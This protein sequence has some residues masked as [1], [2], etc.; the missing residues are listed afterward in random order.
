MTTHDGG[1]PEPAAAYA[2]LWAGATAAPRNEDSPMYDALTSHAVPMC[3]NPDAPGLGGSRG[4]IAQ[5]NGG[6]RLPTCLVAPGEMRPNRGV[7]IL[8]VVVGVRPCIE[9]PSPAPVSQQRRNQAIE[10]DLN[11]LGSSLRRVIVGLPPRPTLVLVLAPAPSA[12]MNAQGDEV[13]PL[14][15]AEGAPGSLFPSNGSLRALTS[16]TTRQEGLVANVDV[17]PTILRFFGIPIP[18]SMD[19]EPIRFT[20]DPA[21]FDLHRRELEQRR[22]RLPVQFAELAFVV[23][24]GLAAIGMLFVFGMRRRVDPRAASAMRFVC[25]VAAALLPAALAGGWLPHLTYPWVFVFL[26]VAMLGLAWLSLRWRTEAGPF[27]PFVF[28]GLIGLAIFAVDAAFGQRAMRV[29]LFGG[30]MFDGV[31]FY[32]LPN[33]FIAMLLASALF[34][35]VV[36]DPIPG[37]AVL[38]G[39][40][41]FAGFPSLGADVG[42]AITLSFAAGL[43]L[44]LRHPRRLGWIEAPLVAGITLAGLAVTLLANRFL[45]GPPT[46]AT[47]F[48]EQSGGRLGHAFTTLRDR[49]AVGW[50][51][52]ERV[53]AALIPLI[54]LAVVLWLVLRRTGPVAAGMALDRRWRE[55]MV[56]LVAASLVAYFANDT[57][58]AAADPAFIYA[59]AGIVYPAMLVAGRP[60]GASTREP[61]P[62]G[63]RT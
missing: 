59:M 55:A 35:A 30:T 20:D 22:V 41:L 48:V 10:R 25:L 34:V 11:E 16:D 37:F 40:A 13:T 24:G 4:G 32:G 39:A 50:H 21:P 12:E 52:I 45:P 8:D 53:P 26:P 2:T 63:A 56:S 43:W 44:V 51:M 7:A 29:P 3:G 42:G 47:R 31:R 15:M 1:G 5:L 9:C 58:P 38:V 61:S 6:R 28:L 14:L 60:N 17:A 62:A 46:H 19:G 36:L 54:G 49:L 27:A 57:G 33:G 23:V 18:S